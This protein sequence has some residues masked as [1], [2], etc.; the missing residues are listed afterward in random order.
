MTF[1]ITHISEDFLKS[2]TQSGIIANLAAAE[3]ALEVGFQSL[4]YSRLSAQVL[5]KM[6]AIERQTWIEAQFAA[7]KQG[8]VVIVQYPF[9]IGNGNFEMQM[10]ETL[11]RMPRLK[12]AA[13]V[14]D[15][16][17]WVQDDRDRD[18]RNDPSLSMLN[19][20][21]LVICANEKMAGRL[22]REGG[23]K[24]PLLSWQ[25]SDY[26]YQRPLQKKNL[27]KQLYY[28]STVIN[29][30][31]LEDYQANTPIYMIGPDYQVA[32]HA[33][34]VHL[35]GKMK[36]SDIP[37]L[38]DG[39]FGMIEYSRGGHYAGMQRYGHYNNP[40]K[41]SL[42]LAS[43]LPPLVM[44]HSAHAVWIREKNVGLVL[45]DLNEIDA[46]LEKMTEADYQQILE[47]LKP[48]QKAVSTGFF[49]KRA[50]LE[51]LQFLRLGFSDALYADQK[52]DERKNTDD[53][54]DDSNIQLK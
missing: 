33:D 36:N 8:D 2:E 35:L 13:L 34:N 37:Q 14:W 28:V 47:N 50:C 38:F 49:V 31:L 23:V 18:Y 1:W 52:A 6:N 30:T 12:L 46:V 9:W 54:L 53:L 26:P 5:Q 17:S 15:I 25:L 43:G 40:M 24:S 4:N 45:D 19:S 32:S 48:W 39:G 44:S 16:L 27:K 10:I 51:A 3:S 41:L 22:R 21:D 42:Y 7:V 20:F 11:R 29:P